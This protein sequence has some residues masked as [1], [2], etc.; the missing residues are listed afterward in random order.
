[1]RSDSVGVLMMST[2]FLVVLVFFGSAF[3]AVADG[4]STAA[5]ATDSVPTGRTAD[6]ETSSDPAPGL[7][8][9]K[10]ATTSSAD[11][12]ES[13]ANPEAPITPTKSDAPTVNAETTE[14]AAQGATRSAVSA[15]AGDSAAAS[16]ASA[17]LANDPGTSVAGAQSTIGAFDATGVK[18]GAPNT[19]GPGTSFEA[20]GG[21][22][23]GNDFVQHPGQ[24]TIASEKGVTTES[25]KTEAASATLSQGGGA[26][27]TGPEKV[28]HS[29][30]QAATSEAK[31]SDDMTKVSP[32]VEEDTSTKVD[33]GKDEDKSTKELQMEVTPDTQIK[34]EE[35][36]LTVWEAHRGLFI[37]IL[38]MVACV[39]VIGALCFVCFKCR[40]KSPSDKQRITLEEGVTVPMEASSPITDAEIVKDEAPMQEVENPAV[41]PNGG[42]QH[43]SKDEEDNG[44]VVPLEELS[45]TEKE[46]PETENTKL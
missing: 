11:Q 27:Q 3:V 7:E 8:T 18:T 37:G 5:A 4:A 35:S 42:G 22:S 29:T 41:T 14:P 28:P 45:K 16:A 13:T 25:E 39:I 26:S 2:R 9:S 24:S 12:L 33:E 1:M 38:I 32:E 31:V 23:T 36:R 20:T 40:E 46:K 44:W 15:A 30:V 10:A 17:A 19:I 6:H 43:I 21:Q 34:G